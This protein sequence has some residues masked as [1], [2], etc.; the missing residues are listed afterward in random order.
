MKSSKNHKE[1]KGRHMSPK[2]TKYFETSLPEGRKCE[3]NQGQNVPRRKTKKKKKSIINTLNDQTAK[4]T[5]PDYFPVRRS[6]RKTKSHLL[7]EKEKDLRDAILSQREDGLK[8]V[9]FPDKGRGVKATK[10]FRRGDFVVEYFG[11]LIDVKE[12]KRREVI[13]SKD[14]G[15]GCYMYYFTLVKKY[16]VDATAESGRLGRLVNHSRR[17]NLLTKS[18]LVGDVPRLILVAKSDIK[19]GEELLFDYGD[20]CRSSL[21]D[22]PWLAK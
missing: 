19:V 21:V 15:V 2:I 22:H 17:G 13:Y 20:R 3:E 1:N 7:M 9:V 10:V 11:E 4:Q 6:S 8:V 16:C 12:A 18:L 5:I 14:E